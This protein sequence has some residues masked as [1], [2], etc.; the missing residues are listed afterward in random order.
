MNKI[1]ILFL[2]DNSVRI[3]EAQRVYLN[4]DRVSVLTIVKTAQSAIE[5]LKSGLHYHLV[6][7]DHDLGGETYVNSNRE[8]CGM[9]VARWIIENNPDNIDVIS[10]HSW[11]TTAS[12]GMMGFLN[13]FKKTGNAHYKY[14]FYIPFAH[15]GW[16]IGNRLEMN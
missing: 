16:D 4:N 6:H 2:D 13:S 10:I 11:N 14:V 8:D 12:Y 9:E 7:L 3:A 15:S 1:N 5:M